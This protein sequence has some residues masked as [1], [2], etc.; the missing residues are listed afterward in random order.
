MTTLEIRLSTP[1]FIVAAVAAA[2]TI[3]SLAELIVILRQLYSV[4]AAFLLCVVTEVT[5]QLN[6]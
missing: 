3:C 1:G 2:A 6:S 5:T 4:K